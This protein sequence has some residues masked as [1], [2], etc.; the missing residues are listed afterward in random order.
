MEPLWKFEDCADFLKHPE[1]LI[2]IWA[3]E[4]LGEI[5]PEE[6]LG[7]LEEARKDKHKKVR[8]S[9]EHYIE[10]HEKEKE[11]LKEKPIINPER[12]SLR[13]C[14]NYLSGNRNPGKKAVIEHLAKNPSLIPKVLN[15]LE[16]RNA[17]F[18]NAAAEILIKTG[19]EAFP[20]L[21]ETIERGTSAR[22]TACLYAMEMLPFR[23][24]ADIIIDNFPK[25]WD[26]HNRALLE[27]VTALGSAEFIPLIKE[28]LRPGEYACERTYCILCL[29]NGVRDEIL[30]EI[31]SSIE[32]IDGELD[33]DMEAL[34]Q[35]RLENFLEDHVTL[36]LKCENCGKKYNYE[37]KKILLSPT[38][39]KKAP[40]VHILDSVECK[41]CGAID[42]YSITGEAYA[43]I[44]ARMALEIASESRNPEE[45]TGGEGPL[46]YA[47]TITDGKEMTIDDSVRYYRKK[48]KR[49]P[50]NPEY[51]VA[52][53]NVLMTLKQHAEA[54]QEYK[55]A[56][57]LEDR[58]VEAYAS[59]SQIY[60][61]RGEEDKAR[62]FV[63]A[64]VE[65]LEDGVFYRAL[66]IEE[67]KRGAIRNLE[68]FRPYKV[69]APVKTGKIPRN[70]PCPCG[71]GKKYKKCCL[72]KEI[73]GA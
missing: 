43:V 16:R 58:A 25:L 5:F 61:M 20:F 73:H 13:R 48:I 4:R 45:E 38:T 27:A 14:L 6:A 50:L 69:P 39:G 28:E 36:L 67:F 26:E 64:C 37:L 31:R 65:R 70:A 57:E 29:L 1:Y 49:D 68:Y 46:L 24:S 62:Q 34:R 30:P 10:L 54:E 17:G 18:F 42:R 52:F 55:K 11:L 63:E 33:N 19:A 15:A 9:A 8:R 47:R 7:L 56:L 40:S 51:R 41:N 12:A 59:L 44:A 2:R 60:F 32:E 53:G 22:I 71:S 72:Y 66:D 35:N 23:E 21:R 3:C